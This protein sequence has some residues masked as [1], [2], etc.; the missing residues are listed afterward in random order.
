M[1]FIK[2]L[3]TS[4]FGQI[5][6]YSIIKYIAL[7][8]GFLKG[9]INAKFLG[10]DLLGV[11]GNL[12]LILGYCTYAN[13][14]IV[15]SMNR[16]YVLA[17]ENSGDESK[18]VLST[19]FTFLV[20]LSLLFLCL[21]LGS[22]F[23]YKN[24]FGI[25]LALIFLIAIFEQFKNYFVNYFRLLDN[26]NM[27]NLIEV[28]YSIVA[29]ILTLLL[30]NNYKIY[31]VLFAMLI[32]GIVI[33]IVCILKANFINLKI[34]K[35]ILKNLISIGIPLLIYNLGFYILTTIDRWI[36]LRY[37][38]D[39]DLG[40][41]TFANSMVNAT[42]VFISS[43]LFLLYPKL[44][45][46]FNE[47]RNKNIEEKVKV[48]TKLLEVSSA[49]FFSIGVIIFKPFVSIVVNKYLDSIGIYMILLI[50]II[51]NN[52]SYFANSYIVSNKNQKYLVYLQ[53][54]S[55]IINLSFNLLF[56]KIGMG[57]IGVALGTLIANAIY[58]YIQY[59]LFFKLN[60]SKFNFVSTFKVYCRIFIYSIVISIMILLQVRYSIYILVVLGLT[61]ALYL[62][63][64]KKIDEYIKILKE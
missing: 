13:L 53:V 30:I 16:E 26:Y 54:I 61:I 25:Y 50:A 18:D 44:I 3:R 62:N 8:F 52:L 55:G 35:R 63:E 46:A 4:K 48:Y 43:I 64:L 19:S 9:I 27:I 36:I 2:K 42:L 1:E 5:F 31:G 33:L 51:I 24:I 58:S 23:A 40:Y 15:H 21:S 34:D 60:S 32:C 59:S 39:S 14:G 22:I 20:I 10:P 38:T 28:I 17:N 45:K 6:R 37:Y 57:V 29:F 41:Y 12:T 47:G 56:V 7:G 11:L 49:I